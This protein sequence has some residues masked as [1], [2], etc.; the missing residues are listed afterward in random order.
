MTINIVNY[1]Y[2]IG[3]KPT[4]PQQKVCKN[5]AFFHTLHKHFG[6]QEL[7][8]SNRNV[9]FPAQFS[10]FVTY[11]L[12]TIYIPYNTLKMNLS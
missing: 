5:I 6:Q 1:G 12:H 7:Q 8:Q 3:T 9:C 2:A 10:R 11:Q 4:L